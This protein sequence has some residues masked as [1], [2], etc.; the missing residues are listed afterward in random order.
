MGFWAKVLTSMEWMIA[1]GVG[2]MI[3]GGLGMLVGYALRQVGQPKKKKH[4]VSVSKED[5]SHEGAVG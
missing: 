2:M 5:D 1:I 4:Y 3:L